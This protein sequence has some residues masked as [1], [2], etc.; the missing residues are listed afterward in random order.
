MLNPRYTCVENKEIC[1]LKKFVF[2]PEIIYIDIYN[3]SLSPV[4]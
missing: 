1:K 3:K 2:D 4:E